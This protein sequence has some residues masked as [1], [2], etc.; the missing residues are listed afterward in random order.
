MR[1]APGTNV[2]SIIY[3][4]QVIGPY[5]LECFVPGMPFQSSILFISK[6]SYLIKVENRKVLQLV[7]A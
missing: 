3:S 4:S 5:K 7:G 1:L 6:A 2:K